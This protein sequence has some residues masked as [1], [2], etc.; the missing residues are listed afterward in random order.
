MQQ[1]LGERHAA[2]LAGRPV[3]HALLCEVQ[4]TP[5]TSARTTP[6]ATAPRCRP[7]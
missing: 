1:D 4:R 3:S 2:A 5:L 6:T 7:R